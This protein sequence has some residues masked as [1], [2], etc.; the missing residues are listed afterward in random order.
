MALGPAELLP[1]LDT[2]KVSRVFVDAY[3][4]LMGGKCPEC[5]GLYEGVHE[6]CDPCGKA[7]V[8]GFMTQEVVAHA[9]L[10]PPPPI[11]FVP[12]SQGVAQ[13]VRRDGHSSLE[14]KGVRTN[15]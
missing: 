14:N 8:A 10:H 7:L 6:R 2:R 1:L 4:P 12:S 15:R 3:D 13:G 5:S 11:T 9:V